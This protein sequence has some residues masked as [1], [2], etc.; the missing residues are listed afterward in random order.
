MSKSY[1]SKKGKPHT[2]FIKIDRYV[3]KTDAW[4]SLTPADKAVYLILLDRFKGNNNGDISLSIREAAEHANI[5]KA[6]AGKAFKNLEKKGFIKKRFEG[7]FS[8]KK[9]LSSEYELTHEGYNGRAP[10]KE[11][12]RYE[13]I[14]KHHVST[15]A[16]V[17]QCELENQC[18][19]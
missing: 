15:H 1:R 6:T 16:V 2:S 3:L 9:R 4:K 5:A 19:L 18:V 10:T 14:P 7:S 13:A 12:T 17:V 8:Q 11:F